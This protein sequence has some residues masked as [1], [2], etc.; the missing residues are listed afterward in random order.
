[1]T[2]QVLNFRDASKC[3]NITIF[4]TRYLL[5]FNTQSFVTYLHHSEEEG[6]V[7]TTFLL[8]LPATNI[9]L[10]MSLGVADTLSQQSAF[11]PY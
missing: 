5:F 8:Q 6:G 3:R 10:H 2:K 4:N 11:R 7:P 9:S 1:M